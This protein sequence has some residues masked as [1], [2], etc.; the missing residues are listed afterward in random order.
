MGFFE[1]LF[2]IGV[3]VFMHLDDAAS[4]DDIITTVRRKWR[5]L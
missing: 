1:V 2:W 4:S 3:L 5:G